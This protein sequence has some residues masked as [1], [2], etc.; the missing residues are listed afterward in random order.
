MNFI[1]LEENV[2]VMNNKK[3]KMFFVCFVFCFFLFFVS[4]CMYLS[5][6]ENLFIV[7]KNCS[8]KKNCFFKSDDDD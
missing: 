1:N 7:L 4:A 8:Q 2:C 6:A 3:V 5:L